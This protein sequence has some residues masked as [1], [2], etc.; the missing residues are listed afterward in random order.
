[1]RIHLIRHGETVNNLAHAID[2]GYPGAHLSDLGRAQAASL[3][4][5]LAG[6]NF[7]ALYVSCLRRT[8]ETAMPLVAATGLTPIPRHGLREIQA[9]SWEMKTSEEDFEGYFSTLVRWIRGDVHLR[10]GGGTSGQEVLERYDAVISEIE[11]SGAENVAVISHGAVI[12]FWTAVR[13]AGVYETSVLD[14]HLQNTG[15]CVIEGSLCKGY[16]AVSWMGKKI[17][18]VFGKPDASPQATH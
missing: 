1:M 10:Q 3:V 17:G 4:D 15:V 13:A 18:E 6:E 14:N 7:D 11:E 5:R 16:R 9:G 12:G 2:T 8:H